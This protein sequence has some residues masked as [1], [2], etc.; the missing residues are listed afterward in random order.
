PD[1]IH[2]TA[3]RELGA[4]QASNYGVEFLQARATDVQMY[5]DGRERRFCIATRAGSVVARTL[6]LATGVSDR[7]PEFEGSMECIGK[8]M[9]WCIICDGYEAIDKRIVVLG[10]ND[11]A[12]S[13]ALELLVFTSH[14]TL[15]SWDEPLDL[16]EQKLRTLK[17]HGIAVHE[18]G[19]KV[20]HCS[21]GQISSITL[22]NGS[23]LELDMLFVAQWIEPN[24][25]LAKKLS[26][27]LDEHGYILTDAEQNTNVEGVYAAGDVTKLH[28]HQVTSAV[29]EGGMAAAAAN[30]Y[31]YEDWQKE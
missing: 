12:A 15:V 10:H 25:Q 21:K 8:S 18:C 6:I 4:M 16:S 14:V 11:R 1:G 29:H 17:E 26:I 31:L 2:A 9:F 7:F 19:C 23:E 22:E 5:G 20:Y 30:Y 28:N 24:T 27:T 3:L 13:L